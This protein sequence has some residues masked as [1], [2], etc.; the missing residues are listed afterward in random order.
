M[1][2][3]RAFALPAVLAALVIMAMVVA[4]SAQRALLAARLSG[5]EV[6]RADMAAA[7]LAAQA[8]ALEVAAD[9]ARCAQLAPRESLASGEQRAGAARA[10]WQ[11]VGAAAPF[12]L[13]EIAVD[14]PVFHGRA[15]DLH[16]ALVVP[17]PD[18]A[19]GLR[20]ALAG[21]SGWSRVP[22]P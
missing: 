9:S 16:R 11:L 15:R 20:W 21:A 4:I 1:T 7:A 17:R 19:G 10:R 5:L 6:A 2:R 8:A 18:T 14:A 22:S 12:A 3:R 13:I